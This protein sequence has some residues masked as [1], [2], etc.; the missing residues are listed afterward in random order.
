[1]N[2]NKIDKQLQKIKLEKRL[3]LMTQI[4]VGYHSLAKTF[5]IVKIMEKNGADFVELQIPFSDP[6]ADGPTIMKACEQAL[7]NGTKVK[8]A[9]D[10]VGIL[11]G[12]V[13][14]PLLFMAYLNTVYKYGIEKFCKDASV[15]GISGLIVPDM[16]IEEEQCE[17]FNKYCKKYNLKNIKVL[18]PASTDE[19]LKKNSHVANG[20]VYFTARQGITG[21]KD[22]LDPKIQSYLKKIKKYFSVPIAVGFGISKRE[23]MR[24]LKDNADIAVVGSAIIDVINKSRNSEVEQRVGDFIDSLKMVN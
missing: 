21:A 2:M 7:M 20:F 19:R 8:D 6:L 10:V 22:K 3:G 12:E 17:H 15:A 16:P 9:F 1:M 13:T 24:V 5:D 23:H 18:S 14:I 4:V 11:S